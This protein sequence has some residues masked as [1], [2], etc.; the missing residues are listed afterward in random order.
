[1]QNKFLEDVQKLY[2]HLSEKKKEVNKLYSFLETNQFDQLE[3]IDVMAQKLGL[4]MSED[5]RVAL[6][7]RLVSLRD[8]SFVQVL[9]KREISEEKIVELVEVAYK[10]VAEFWNDYHNETIAYIQEEN[11]LTP[12]YR[13]IFKGVYQVGIAMTVWQSSWTALI[14]NGVNKELINKFKTD[15]KVMEFLE[16]NNLFDLGHDELTADR[17]YSVLLKDENNEYKSEA[18]IKAFKKE[19]LSVIDALE[20]FSDSLIELEDEIYG[21]KWEYVKYIQSLIT[22]FSEKRPDRLVHYWSEVD[23]AWME[24]TSPIQIGHPLEYYEDHY[25]KAVALEWDIRLVN[26]TYQS[27]NQRAKKLKNMSNEL[28]LTIDSEKK[29]KLLLIF[30]KKVWTKCNSILVV[31]HSFLGLN[32]TD[33]FQ[34]KLYQMMKKYQKLA[35]KKSLLL[36]MRYFKQLVRSHF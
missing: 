11:L 12:F 6:V 26:P 27:E 15:E 20:E 34:L 16:I 14:I 2:D 1:M 4:E 24:I 3:I 36:V 32:I 29:Y 9:K 25:R 5:L 13:E 23:R 19:V 28:Y 31:L 17:S 21:Q 22:A 7:G 33:F 10:V 35:E 8:D 30:V 18:Y